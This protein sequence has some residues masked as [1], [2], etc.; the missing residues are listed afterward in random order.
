MSNISCFGSPFDELVGGPPK[1]ANKSG[2]PTTVAVKGR[3][4][5]SPLPSPQNQSVYLASPSMKGNTTVNQAVTDDTKHI[6]AKKKENTSSVDKDLTPR[7]SDGVQ[8]AAV[9]RDSQVEEAK[10]VQSLLITL[11]K[12]NPK[13]MNIKVDKV[14]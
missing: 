6:Q 7:S 10:D 2:L 12:E 8:E 5:A 13:G 14:E 4:S 1:A 3:H 9:P 11:L